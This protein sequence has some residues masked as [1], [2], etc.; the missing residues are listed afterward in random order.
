MA[1]SFRLNSSGAIKDHLPKNK[2]LQRGITTPW[3]LIMR[4]FLKPLL[5]GSP[6]ALKVVNEGR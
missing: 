4:T 1:E 5:M 6:R 2:N 3:R